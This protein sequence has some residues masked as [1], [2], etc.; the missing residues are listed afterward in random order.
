VA[1][2][3]TGFVNSSETSR[4][5]FVPIFPGLTT[6]P[7]SI[8]TKEGPEYLHRLPFR[9]KKL[10]QNRL[11]SRLTRTVRSAP[12]GSI[13]EQDCIPHSRSRRYNVPRDGEI[14]PTVSKLGRNLICKQANPLTGFRAVEVGCRNC[15]ANYPKYFI[16]NGLASLH[17]IGCSKLLR[18]ILCSQWRLASTTPSPSS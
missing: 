17:F 16:I 1:A 9:P 13:S 12:L 8:L 6:G 4:R 10:H 15:K 18:C 2:H 14:H 11:L 5:G 7:A 3:W